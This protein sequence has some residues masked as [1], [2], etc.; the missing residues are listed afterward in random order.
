MTDFR[1]SFREI[2]VIETPKDESQ[3]KPQ[4]YKA[5]NGNTLSY[6]GKTLLSRID[7]IGQAERLVNLLDIKERTLYVCPS[8]LYGYGLDLLVKKLAGESAVLCI[9][10]DNELFELSSR[11]M[12]GLIKGST[13]IRMARVGALSGGAL[14]AFVNDSWGKRR[15]RR[16][17]LLQISG[18]WQLFPD[19]YEKLVSDLRRDMAVSWGN[20]MTLIRLGRLYCRNLIRNLPLLSKYETVSALNYGA[21]PVLVLGAGP[22]LD[23]VLNSLGSRIKNPSKRPFRII[24]A[25]TCVLPLKDR[26]IKPDLVV[27]LES[28]HWN[29]RD[30]TG[31]RDWGCQAAVDLSCLPASAN[32]LGGGLYLFMTPWT[33][34]NLFKRLEQR[35][36]LPPVL[37]P[38]G[39]VGLSAMELAC[40][41]T[42][43]PVISGGMDFSFT[44]DAYHARSTPGHKSRLACLN[45][46]L[47]PL[48]TREAFREGTFPILSKT[49]RLVRSG[50]SMRGYREMFEEEFS[51]DERIFELSSSGLHLGCK[52]ISLDEAV[53]ILFQGN[54]H[55]PSCQGASPVS[56]D[57]REALREKT[58]NFITGEK[59]CLLS[60]KNMLTGEA[61]IG[62]DNNIEEIFNALDYLWAHFPESAGT[63][64]SRPAETGVSFLKRVRTEIDPFLKLWDLALRGMNEQ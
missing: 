52:I 24:C 40:R 62:P 15:F 42:S 56:L 46:F 47:S 64:G 9:E 2:G 25:D 37:T 28:Q 45:R 12:A 44:V 48:N 26:G 60:L 61:Q 41:I 14:C 5:R 13:D 50:P 31:A 6:K 35:S 3:E 36:L 55:G 18:G 22:S 51:R 63:G 23:G 59:A 29:L 21:D 19:V 27:I 11:Y 20:A 38:L 8:P 33:E 57:K 4:E 49:G 1:K 43:G 16:V 32:V 10:A 54:G 30:F 7:P 34:L 17:E 39:S 53:S 58:E